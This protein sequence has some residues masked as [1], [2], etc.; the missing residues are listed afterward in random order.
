[1]AK[2]LCITDETVFGTYDE[3]AGHYDDNGGE[4]DGPDW[5]PNGEGPD[6]DSDAVNEII[7]NGQGKIVE[8][9][10][11][12]ENAILDTITFDG[13]GRVVNHITGEAEDVDD[14]YI[15]LLKADVDEMSTRW[16]HY[17]AYGTIDSM[18]VYVPR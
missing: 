13:T 16:A 5:L 3:L 7:R 8:V 17:G 10:Y 12:K 4:P 6:L 9:R 11:A 15:A 2:V 18:F 1:M 14:S